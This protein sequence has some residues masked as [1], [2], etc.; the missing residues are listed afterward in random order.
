MNKLFP[1]DLLVWLF[2]LVEFLKYF[3]VR[4]ADVTPLE[5]LFRIK[6]RAQEFPGFTAASLEADK[7]WP[8]LFKVSSC[9]ESVCLFILGR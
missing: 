4:N 3:Q 8:R 2:N 1:I 7:L 5:M 9:P 6:L